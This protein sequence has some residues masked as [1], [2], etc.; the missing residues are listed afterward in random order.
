MNEN[1]KRVAVYF[2]VCK[3]T[4]MEIHRL[5]HTLQKALWTSYIFVKNAISSLSVKHLLFIV[6]Y[7]NGLEY[8][9]CHAINH[10]VLIDIIGLAKKK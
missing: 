2:K 1:V 6:S 8:K 9:V 4:V 3:V 10:I 7:L 5:E